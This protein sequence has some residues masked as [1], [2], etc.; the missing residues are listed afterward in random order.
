[1]LVNSSSCLPTKAPFFVTLGTAWEGPLWKDGIPSIFY[2]FSNHTTAT[3]H[4][5]DPTLLITII[6][7]TASLT[8][9]LETLFFACS[10]TSNT[11]KCLQP[12]HPSSRHSC[13]HQCSLIA[14]LDLHLV[15]ELAISQ[16]QS[17]STSIEYIRSTKLHTY[18]T[19]NYMK[20]KCALLHHNST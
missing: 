20:F 11:L 14:C 8:R 2:A 6:P 9:H 12:Y 4:Q 10:W 3:S 5:N 16:K 13:H 17:T 7:F 19:I 1:M 15:L 18:V